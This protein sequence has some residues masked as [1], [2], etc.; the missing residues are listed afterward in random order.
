MFVMSRHHFEA[1]MRRNP[2]LLVRRD[3]NRRAVS[4]V[5]HHSERVAGLR[6]V[7]NHANIL[8]DFDSRVMRFLRFFRRLGATTP[9]CGLGLPVFFNRMPLDGPILVKNMFLRR[10]A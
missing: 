2:V 3:S 6:E 5:Q 4:E 1:S 9:G 8:G 10:S 7:G